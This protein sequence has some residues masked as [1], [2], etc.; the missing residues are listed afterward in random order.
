MNDKYIQ[1]GVIWE[2]INNR[3]YFIANRNIKEGEGIYFIKNRNR[4]KK[5][6]QPDYI[7]FDY[8]DKKEAK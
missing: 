5:N 2:S 4:T 8:K 7:S 6:N 3:L 1:N